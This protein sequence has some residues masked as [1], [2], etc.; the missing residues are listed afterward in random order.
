MDT[1]PPL[2]ERC[3]PQTLDKT[4][5]FS[6]TSRTSARGAFP[7]AS[8]AS[9]QPRVPM[10]VTP[11]R[12]VFLDVDGVLCCN[13]DAL[14]EPNKMQQLVRITKETG[15][16]VCISSN[17]RLFEDLREHLYAQ[18]AAAGIDCIGTT[19]DAGEATHGEC[20]RPCEI[21]AWIKSWHQDKG[22]QRIAS[23]V[24]VDDRSL[25]HEK[26]GSI[27]RGAP[28]PSRLIA[29]T[30]LALPR[31]PLRPSTCRRRE[32]TLTGRFVRTNAE[33]GLTKSAATLV[34]G[35]LLGRRARGT[36]ASP[37]SPCSVI[38]GHADVI[39]FDQPLRVVHAGATDSEGLGLFLC[40]MNELSLA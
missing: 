21:G 14:I 40:E 9:R 30:P 5:R 16:K 12:V 24:A 18:L 17:W 11:L 35:L 25:L 33:L 37:G 28:Q 3:R 29:M 1:P 6:C 23:F 20:M 22:R 31:D 4:Y 27:L 32:R 10:P 39:K 19:P 36:Y 8:R 15:A 38:R 34:I 2:A 13:Q 7:T 26:G